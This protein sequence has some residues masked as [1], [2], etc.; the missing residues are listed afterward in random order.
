M[1]ICL[2]EVDNTVEVKFDGIIGY[3]EFYRDSESIY[4]CDP[5][6]EGESLVKLLRILITAN[7]DVMKYK[8]SEIFR[9]ACSCLRGELGIAVLPL[10]LIS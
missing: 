6:S 2:I 5:G 9:V 10:F 7:T 3:L 4:Q 1:V 8:N